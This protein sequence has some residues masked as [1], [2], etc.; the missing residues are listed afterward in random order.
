MLLRSQVGTF[1]VKHLDRKSALDLSQAQVRDWGGHLEA[2]QLDLLWRYTQ[3]LSE[4]T[5]ANVIGSKDMYSILLDHVLDSL[6]CLSLRSVRLQGKIVDVGSGGGLPGIPLAIACP[7]LDVT[8]MEATYKKVKFLEYAIDELKLSNVNVRNARAESAGLTKELRDKTSLAVA[9]ALAFL[10]VV[11]EYCAPFVE[12]G[13]AVLSMKGRLDEDELLAGRRAA[14]RIGAEL[15]DVA[16]IQIRPELEQK[17]RHI[18]IFR[19]IATTPDGYPR[20]VGLAK[21]RPLGG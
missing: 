15:A 17:Q 8:L 7:G 9:R 6:S 14:T 18:V 13:G 2:E 4:Y 3:L 1:H 5:E 10:P 21:K 11:L 19:K 16:Q 20:R 12:K